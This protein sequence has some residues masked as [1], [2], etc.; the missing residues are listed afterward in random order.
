[1]PVTTRQEI[2][3]SV[4]EL[5]REFGYDGTSMALI[6]DRTNLGKASLYHHF[7]RGKEQMREEIVKLVDDW[8][9]PRFALLKDDSAPARDRIKRFVADLDTF[10]AGGQRGCLLAALAVGN[11]DGACRTNLRG[12]LNNWIAAFAHVAESEGAPADQAM[13][14]AED[15][16]AMIEG[17]LLVSRIMDDRGI[18]KRALLM[19]PDMLLG[20]R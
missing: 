10:F 7:P 6:S 16:V 20:L 3:E 5:F 1:M 15:C 2:L 14:R 9:T 8:L 12:V 4:L 11:P 13:S 17:A 19:A 18:F